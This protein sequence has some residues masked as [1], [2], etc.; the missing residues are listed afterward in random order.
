M[1]IDLQVGIGHEPD[2]HEPLEQPTD[3]APATEP[4]LAAPAPAPAPEPKSTLPT[5]RWSDSK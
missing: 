4:A 3:E 1:G 2:K 5:S